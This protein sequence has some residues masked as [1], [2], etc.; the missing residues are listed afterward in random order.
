MKLTQ[1]I[2]PFLSEQLTKKDFDD[3]FVKIYMTVQMAD[4]KHFAKPDE[5]RMSKEGGK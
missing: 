1:L 5:R 2:E 3:S 4:H